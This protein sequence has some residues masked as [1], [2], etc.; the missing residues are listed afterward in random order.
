MKNIILII[1]ISC[2]NILATAQT[3]E[4]N[5]SI[6]DSTQAIPYASVYLKN[7]PSVGV[8]A[9]SEGLFTLHVQENL[10]P[11][12]LVVSFVGYNTYY[13]PID[14][15]YRENLSIT[16]EEDLINLEE[17]NIVSEER[18]K[19]R[20]EMNELLS[21]VKQQ[22]LSDM[23]NVEARYHTRSKTSIAS[24]EQILAYQEALADI[25]EEDWKKKDMT[26]RISTRAYINPRLSSLFNN[27]ADTTVSQDEKQTI[28]PTSHIKGLTVSSS[29]IEDALNEPARKWKYNGQDENHYILTFKDKVG[30]LGIVK[31]RQTCVLYIDKLTY[32]IMRADNSFYLYVNIPFG[33]KVPE[34]YMDMVN[35]LNVS[36]DITLDKFRLKKA[37]ADFTMTSAFKHI[38]GNMY[39]SDSYAHGYAHIISRKMTLD[40]SLKSLQEI[41]SMDISSPTPIT[42]EE[43]KIEPT[44]EIIDDI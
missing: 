28:N 3:L 19:N 8:M 26:R 17:V 10:L 35:M 36:S 38:D 2:S 24:S 41:L 13:T 22:F 18:V 27:D 37:E 4:I 9:S 12:T 7:H 16:L 34:E 21:I 30:L 40:V 44:L 20:V 42:E 31:F 33:K 43:T 32:S 6:K 23:E 15:G 11:D 5:G 14:T 29:M 25:Y 39:R 1:L